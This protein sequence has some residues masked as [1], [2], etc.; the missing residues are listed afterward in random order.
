M[1]RDLYALFGNPV[2]QS[3]SPVMMNAAFA[4]LNMPARY[5]AFQVDHAADIRKRMDTRSLRIRGAS[6]TCSEPIEA[7][8]TQTV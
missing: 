7:G 5:E 6:V 8:N 4:K 2:S 1:T 3:L